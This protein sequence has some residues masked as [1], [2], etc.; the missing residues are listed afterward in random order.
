MQSRGTAR[1]PPTGA[2]ASPKPLEKSPVCD[3][4]SLGSENRQPTK[5]SLSFP[6]LVQCHL[7]ASVWQDQSRPSAWLQNRYRKHIPLL[8][9]R[10]LLLSPALRSKAG[11]ANRQGDVDLSEAQVSVPQLELWLGLASCVGV[12]PGPEK[13]HW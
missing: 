9:L 11:M 8:E 5:Q 3:W 2:V 12:E 6:Q 13:G 4:D 10:C 7:G 1:I